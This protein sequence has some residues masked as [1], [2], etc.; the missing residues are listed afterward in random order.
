MTNT[1]KETKVTMKS[2]AEL[3]VGATE[4]T[5]RELRLIRSDVA[6]IKADVEL[7]KSMLVKGDVSNAEL[8][9]ALACPHCGKSLSKGEVEFCRKHNIE[10]SCYSCRKPKTNR[11]PQRKVITMEEATTKVKYIARCTDADGTHHTFEYTEPTYNKYVA[12]CRELSIPI[13]LCPAC[14]KKFL[15][16]KSVQSSAEQNEVSNQGF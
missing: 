13:L 9:G 2:L 5:T 10:P 1:N 14:A 11:A 12:R 4:T 16:S 7:I 6:T 15:E 3:M 8:A